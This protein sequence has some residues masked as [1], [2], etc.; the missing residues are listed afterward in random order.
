M[1]KRQD[2]VNRYR[3]ALLAGKNPQPEVFLAD[4]PQYRRS[5]SLLLRDMTTAD[6]EDRL[7][8]EQHKL[9]RERLL[10]HMDT[11]ISQMHGSPTEPSMTEGGTNP[12]ATVIP[13]HKDRPPRH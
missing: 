7:L 5:L 1:E 9:G 12:T 6:L 4:Y 13:L 2:I 8:K 10:V 3:T 11:L